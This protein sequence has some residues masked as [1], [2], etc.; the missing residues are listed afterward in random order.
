MSPM[1]HQHPGLLRAGGT[2]AVVAVLAGLL[3]G[4]AAAADDVT[5]EGASGQTLTASTTTG[6]DPAGT[7]VIVTGSGYDESKGIYVAVCVDAGEGERPTPCLGGVDMTGES[8]ASGWFSNNPPSYG[9]DVATPF[10]PDG[11]F[12]VT[13]R[14]VASDDLADC[15]DPTLAPRGCVIATFADHTRISDRSADVLLPLTFLAEGE[16]AATTAPATSEP[17][18]SQAP[19]DDATSAAATTATP[20][21]GENGV[22]RSAAVPG[23]ASLWLPLGGGLALA[24]AVVVGLLV[25]GRR[26]VA[27]ARAQEQEGARA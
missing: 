24:A 5:G 20:G 7:D 9:E 10:G 11:S 16:V 17:A 18:P 22:V 3:A 2:L 8:G 4:P 6:L 15:T 19:S 12:E 27:A 23:G 1:P 25:R 26:R 14:V 13:L 21:T